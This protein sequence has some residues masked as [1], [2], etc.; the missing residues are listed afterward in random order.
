MPRSQ[1]IRVSAVLTPA[2]RNQG[3]GCSVRPDR[4]RSPTLLPS[5]A[6]GG[7]P[8]SIGA[9][10]FPANPGED[11]ATDDP[12]YLI[13]GTGIG[14]GTFRQHESRPATPDTM[15]FTPVQQPGWPKLLKSPQTRKT[16][17]GRRFPTAAV[18]FN[19]L[20]LSMSCHFQ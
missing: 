3:G 16:A 1:S 9:D 15:R 4:R 13:S 19:A 5:M 12:L 18:T 10:D 20:S 14:P 17:P 8:V 11:A 7:L 6:S 2:K